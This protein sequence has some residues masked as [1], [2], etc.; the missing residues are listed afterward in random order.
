MGIAPRSDVGPGLAGL[1]R[2]DR[3]HRS[4]YVD[5]ELFEIELARIFGRAWLF[6]GHESQV[7]KP[8]DFYAT[9]LGRQPVIMVRGADG[10]VRV[11]H[12]RCAH[13]GPM[14]CNEESGT[15]KHFRCAY[16][17]WT[18]ATDGRL[19]SVPLKEGYGAGF[20]KEIPALGLKP[21]PR[22]SAY[23]GFVFASL[24][25]D[26]PPLDAFLGPVASSFDDMVDR[27]PGGEIEVA[28]GIF[29]HYYDG[30]W[31]LYVENVNDLLHPRYVHESSIESAARQDAA[32]RHDGAGDIAR[33]QMIQN[34]VLAQIWDKVNVWT[35]PN[36]H[37]FM[38][39][40]HDDKRLLGEAGDPVIAQYRAALEARHGA[41]R[42]RQILSVSR[43]N[44]IVYPNLTFQSQFRQLRV[45]H[46]LAPGRSEVHVLS[47]RLKGAPERMFED[48]IYFANAINSPASPILTDDLEV[49][50]RAQTGLL[51]EGPEWLHIG[52]GAG[53]DQ[54]DAVG[55]RGDHGTSEIHIRNQFRAWLALMAA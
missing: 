41:E 47:F 3:V 28:G 8:G 22:V 32:A 42:T 24:A 43:F 38:G 6:V 11:L 7:A 27:A 26:G 55:E 2:N 37:S 46:P 15:A 53:H 13:R 25:G 52:R 19:I 5:A 30:N 4:V 50:R 20:D 34:G 14:V 16:H 40:Y 17:G 33:R 36:G 45:I 1:V 10:A 29:K 9:R 18:Y 35:F 51:N 12:N 21:V 23:R 31:K 39:D 54:R 49:Y 44:T 48:T